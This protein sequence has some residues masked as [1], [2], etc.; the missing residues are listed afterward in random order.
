MTRPAVGAGT[1]MAAFSVSSVMSGV[2][3]SICW[4]SWT[5]TSMTLTSL[6]PPMS[7]TLT[8][9]EFVTMRRLDGQGIGFFGIDVEST[10]GVDHR[11][12]V[13]LAVIRQR[14]ERRNCHV[15]PVHL[16][17]AAQLRPGVAAAEAI[18]A[19]HRVSARYPLPDLIGDRFHVVGG[20]NEG[21]FAVA[22]GLLDVVLLPRLVR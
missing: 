10:H 2:S 8:S 17:K 7:G 19:Q 5:S 18:R 9:V 14:L 15:M 4:P 1:S 11:L 13:D 6:N 22:Q 20:G 12:L 16:E 21:P 3:L